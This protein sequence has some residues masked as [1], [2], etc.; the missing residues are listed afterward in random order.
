MKLRLKKAGR[1]LVTG[2]DKEQ[3]TDRKYLEMCVDEEEEGEGCVGMDEKG[4]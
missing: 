3:R 2:W 1:V 4:S